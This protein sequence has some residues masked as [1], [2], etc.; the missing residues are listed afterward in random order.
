MWAEQQPPRFQEDGCTP[1]PYT[2]IEYISAITGPRGEPGIQGPVG[3][4]GD[5]SA[6]SWL[7]WLNV[8][9]NAGE[10]GAL[11]AAIGSIESQ[12][13]AIEA[14][15]A[16]L[17]GVEAAGLAADAIDEVSDVANGIGDALEPFDEVSNATQQQT[18]S[19]TDSIQ[20]LGGNLRSWF[21]RF[22]QGWQRVQTINVSQSYI[23][24]ANIGAMESVEL[25]GSSMV[26]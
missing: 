8:A 11:T 2:F 5:D 12:I 3:P 24:N 26:L 20:R 6:G 1:L 4:K 18:S 22:G 14:E 13:G 16:A 25:L 10:A 17:G 7:D 19:L 15:I 21:Q 23:S 9:M